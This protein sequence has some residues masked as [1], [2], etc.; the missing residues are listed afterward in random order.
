VL[1]VNVTYETYVPLTGPNVSAT[2]VEAQELD[3]STG[4]FDTAAVKNCSLDLWS[5]TKV[6]SSDDTEI[7]EAS[8]TTILKFDSETKKLSVQA[9]SGADTTLLNGAKLIF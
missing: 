4:V 3:L 7:A 1:Q 2:A 5:L 6:N 8:W 9:Y